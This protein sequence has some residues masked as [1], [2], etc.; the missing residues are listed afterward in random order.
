M[1]VYAGYYPAGNQALIV[2]R[3]TDYVVNW[4]QVRICLGLVVAERFVL[5]GSSVAGDRLD[6]VVNWIQDRMCLL[7]FFKIT[8][9]LQRARQSVRSLCCNYLCRKSVILLISF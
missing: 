4:I 3:G 6:D 1:G 2:F 7:A 9:I 8:F 5:C